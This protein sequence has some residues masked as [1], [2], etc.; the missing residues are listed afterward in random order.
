MEAFQAVL[1]RVMIVLQDSEP[2]REF[3]EQNLNLAAEEKL[4]EVDVQLYKYWLIERALED[5]FE[6]LVKWA[7]LRVQIMGG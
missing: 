4:S 3:Q 2:G 5:N 1:E 7:E 6:W